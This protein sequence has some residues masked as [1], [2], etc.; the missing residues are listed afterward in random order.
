MAAIT[1]KRAHHGPGRPGDAAPGPGAER[2]HR[3]GVA[4][5]V[6]FYVQQRG[7]AAAQLIGEDLA[8]GD[9]TKGLQDLPHELRRRGVLGDLQGAQGEVVAAEPM[10]RAAEQAPGHTPS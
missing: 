10:R 1:P 4:L 5:S 3:P 7:L 6:L 2:E 8:L 9:L